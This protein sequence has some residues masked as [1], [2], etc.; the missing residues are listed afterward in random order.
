MCAPA[1]AISRAQGSSLHRARRVEVAR[2][3]RADP[4][5]LSAQCLK[6]TISIAGFAG[7]SFIDCPP[8]SVSAVVKMTYAHASGEIEEFIANKTPTAKHAYFTRI[9][10]CRVRCLSGARQRFVGPAGPVLEGSYPARRASRLL[11]RHKNC[12]TNIFMS[13]RSCRSVIRG[14]F[15]NPIDT[16]RAVL[17]SA[18]LSEQLI[19]IAKSLCQFGRQ[20]DHSS[21]VRSAGRSG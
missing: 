8:I 1:Y 4:P 6:V 11:Y 9:E 13:I 18:L 16:R 7:L 12:R 2:V 10:G 20:T 3:L 17:A 5:S 15:R 19:G 21:A 14:S